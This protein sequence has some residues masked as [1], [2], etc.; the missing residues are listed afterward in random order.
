[1]QANR[2]ICVD[3]FHAQIFAGNA[4]MDL[5]PTAPT[6]TPTA[7]RKIKVNT[8][9]KELTLAEQALKIK[10]CGARRSAAKAKKA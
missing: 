9:K 2:G 3:P 10:K 7:G 6:T 5:A 1:M 8:S 4:A